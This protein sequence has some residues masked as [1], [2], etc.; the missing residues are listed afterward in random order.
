MINLSDPQN[1]L[2]VIAVTSQLPWTLWWNTL[3]FSLFE[4]DTDKDDKDDDDDDF[5]VLWK[6]C[7]VIWKEHHS[8]HHPHPRSGETDEEEGGMDD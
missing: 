7:F 8:T 6:S 4:M 5:A 2:F 3:C 1:E